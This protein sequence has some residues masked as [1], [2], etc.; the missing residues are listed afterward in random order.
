MIDA[1]TNQLRRRWQKLMP[2]MKAAVRAAA[3]AAKPTGFERPLKMGPLP[4]KGLPKPRDA[5][6]RH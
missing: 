6:A 5:E 3:K 4:D 1:E 2:D